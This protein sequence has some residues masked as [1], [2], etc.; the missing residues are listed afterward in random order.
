MRLL[1]FVSFLTLIK[2]AEAEII[3]INTKNVTECGNR[4]CYHNAICSTDGQSCRCRHGYDGVTCQEDVNECEVGS[5]C[6]HRGHCRN[7]FGSW[8]CDCLQGWENSFDIHCENK[9]SPDINYRKCIPGWMGDMCQDQ[10]LND[11]MC[12]RNQNCKRR[13]RGLK[14]LCT[15]GWEGEN[16]TIDVNECTKNPCKDRQVCL[17]TEGSFTCA[18]EDGWKGPNCFDDID[19]C[20]TKNP[21]KN[22]GSC[23]NNNGSYQCLCETGWEGMNCDVDL[24]ECA[25]NPCNISSI[26]M[27]Q[28]G[29]FSCEEQTTNNEVDTGRK[30]LIT[31]IAASVGSFLLLLFL[32]Y[33]IYASKKKCKRK[34]GQNQD[35]VLDARVEQR[36]E[37]SASHVTR[38]GFVYPKDKPA[39]NVQGL[40]F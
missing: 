15:T 36:E 38:L 28:P 39:V 1:L 30:K 35:Q 5:P 20:V 7:T 22:Y 34:V 10:C 13:G 3:D 6:Y 31:V 4:T 29:N 18:C 9:T 19:E 12:G 11:S 32:A 26:C 40:D 23:I 33:V 16:C 21:C 25:S 24:D 8:E 37:I 14:C 2:L 17:N 27:N